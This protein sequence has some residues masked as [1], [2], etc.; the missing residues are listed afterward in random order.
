MYF[1]IQG[2]WIQINPEDYLVDISENGDGSICHILMM[3]N[4]FDFY[5]F[6]LPIFQGY[7][8]IHD[9]VTHSVGYIPLES[10][11]KEPLLQSEPPMTVLDP[12]TE[13]PHWLLTLLFIMVLLA[14]ICGA[15]CV[16]PLLNHYYTQEQDE[17]WFWW[18]CYAC[19]CCCCILFVWAFA[20]LVFVVTIDT[21]ENYTPNDATGDAD[22]NH[23]G[24]YNEGQHYND[25]SGHHQDQQTYDYLQ[26]GSFLSVVAMA[27]YV[28]KNVI[29]ST[30]NKRAALK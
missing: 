23:Q 30:A 28:F 26:I 7:Y 25:G 5:L 16:S 11:M 2:Y 24:E 6:G 8:T 27:S 19:S 20:A 3:S 21:N 4:E 14:V 22:Y 12:E 1:F 13:E 29:L 9:M 18:F 15:I 17:F 10:S